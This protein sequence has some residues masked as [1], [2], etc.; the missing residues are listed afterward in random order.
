MTPENF[1]KLTGDISE[2]LKAGEGIVDPAL[3][4]KFRV[5]Q[6]NDVET[7]ANIQKTDRTLKIGIVGAVKAGKSSFLNALLFDGEDILPKAPTPMTAALTKIVYAQKP[8]AEVYFYSKEEWAYITQKSKEY[9]NAIDLKYQQE[10]EDYYKMMRVN[11]ISFQPSVIEMPTFESVEK[12]YRDSMPIEQRSCYELCEMVSYQC[13]VEQVLAQR[14]LRIESADGPGTELHDYVGASGKYTPLVKHTVLGMNNPMLEG[15][16]IVDTPGLNDPFTSRSKLTENY[17]GQCDVVFVL[18]NISQFLTA[19]D[20]HLINV[21]IPQQGISKAVIVASQLDL[22]LLD[23][24]KI[25][26]FKTALLSTVKTAKNTALSK[27]HDNGLI[28]AALNHYGLL[29][30]S[31][32]FFGIAKKQSAGIPLDENEEHILNQMKIRFG[33]TVKLDPESLTDASGYPEIR[34]RVLTSIRADKEQIIAKHIR[35]NAAEQKVVLLGILENILIDAQNVRNDINQYD[36]EQLWEK[37]KR[38]LTYIDSV[39][40]AIYNAFKTSADNTRKV[41]QRIIHEFEQESFSHRDFEYGTTQKHSTHRRK[42]GWIKKI[43]VTEYWNEKTAKIAD[44]E[45]NIREYYTGIHGIMIDSFETLIALDELKN[46]V[47]N[48]ILGAFEE[49][50]SFNPEEISATLDELLGGLTVPQLEL[51]VDYY[52]TLLAEKLPG[53]AVGQVE[54][55]DEVAQ[56]ESA[57]ARVLSKMSTDVKK[58]MEEKADDIAEKMHLCAATF[59]DEIQRKLSGTIDR[60]SAMLSDK[61]ANL[62]KIDS[63]IGTVSDAKSQLYEASM[64]V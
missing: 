57:Q 27:S 21:S 39:R 33:N 42:V 14:M 24:R 19:E 10:L 13:D 40:R 26:D 1:L 20:M 44:A 18:S 5:R 22:G 35:D 29:F 11:A 64:D 8:F 38:L 45:N 7:V 59:A 15:L 17:L 12:K 9:Y 41:M 56:L 62:K 53:F 54:G 51:D 48:T 3:I 6:K 25:H 58:L 50:D 28:A 55:D 16:E 23:H 60:V 4:E 34:Q 46:K 49:D 31:S 30:T 61:E 52:L 32:V 43:D 36:Y 2:S 63:F 47:K 37:K